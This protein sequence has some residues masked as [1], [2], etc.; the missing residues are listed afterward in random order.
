[1]KRYSTVASVIAAYNTPIEDGGLVE[2]ERNPRIRQATFTE[3][4]AYPAGYVM[5]NGLVADGNQGFIGIQGYGS[6]FSYLKTTFTA[7]ADVPAGGFLFEKKYGVF[8]TLT[9]A[10]EA[11]PDW[12]LD[13]RRHRRYQDE[14]GNPVN[15]DFP[16]GN[17]AE[18][19]RNFR[20]VLVDVTTGMV[21]A[22]EL[23]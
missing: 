17:L 19:E 16:K 4:R 1:M 13:V 7:V 8:D 22:T 11:F 10:I 15:P 9:E 20:Y 23:R 18:A 2:L 5:P 14:Q 12:R 6:F 3:W 21:V